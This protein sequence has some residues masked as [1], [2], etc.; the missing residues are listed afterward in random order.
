MD[1]SRVPE[2]LLVSSQWTN[3]HH[4]LIRLGA[5]VEY[6]QHE[7]GLPDMVFTAN[8]GLVKGN[9]VVLS[10][11]RHKERQGEE[12]HFKKWFLDR[13]FEVL[14]LQGIAFEGE[15]DALFAG[16]NLFCG[17]GFRSDRE[18]CSAIGALLNVKDVIPLTLADP[19]FYHLDT[20]FCPLTPELALVYPGAFVAEDLKRAEKHIELL[21]VSEHD[22]IRFVCNTVV[23]GTDL[24]VPAGCDETYALL[25]K[26]GFRSYPV[27]LS[28]F[29]KAGGAAKCLSLK[30]DRA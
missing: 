4:H 6:V 15:G 18:A 8:A 9:K 10:S 27:A 23:L 22:A 20:C 29:L 14:E 11:F 1:I 30:I 5:Q 16:E 24:V 7:A 3:L 21:P 19:R 28:E 13:G 12:P 17:Q 25:E 2:K 26:R